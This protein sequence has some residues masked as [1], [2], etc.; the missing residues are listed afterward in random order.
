MLF[1]HRSNKPI[2]VDLFTGKYFQ[3]KFTQVGNLAMF[4]TM[5]I[6]MI[7]IKKSMKV[8]GKV[9]ILSSGDMLSQKSRLFHAQSGK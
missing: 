4:S 3:L 2:L 6:M 1:I 9:V 5:I 7:T 8:N